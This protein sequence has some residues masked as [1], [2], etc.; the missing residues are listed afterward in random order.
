M[1]VE[2]IAQASR[3]AEREREGKKDWAK[4]TLSVEMYQLKNLE[5]RSEIGEKTNPASHSLTDT[6]VDTSRSVHCCTSST[7]NHPDTYHVL[8][9][10]YKAG[11]LGL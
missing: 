1:E 8:R 6:R 5:L 9:W 4:L 3:V 11:E 10:E 2:H 7:S